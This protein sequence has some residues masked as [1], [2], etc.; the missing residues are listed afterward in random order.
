MIN[1]SDSIS[2]L[3]TSQHDAKETAL[4][5]VT[6]SAG[7]RELI[8][9]ATR[10]AKSSASILLTGDSGTGKEL[11]AQLIHARSRRQDE[12]FVSVNCASL[13]MNLIESELFG[14][15]KGAF[16]DA[17][18]NRVGRFELAQGGTL[19]LDEITEIPLVTQAKLLRV[20]EAKEFQK[21]GC[22]DTIKTDVRVVA[23]SNRDLLQQVDRGKFRLDLYHRLN[24][25]QLKVPSLKERTNDIPLLASHFVNLFAFENE[26][27]VKGF[28]NA[29]MKKLSRHE[30]P[31]NVRELRNTVHRACIMTDRPL[32][33]ANVLG[34]FGDEAIQSSS[35]LPEMWLQTKL[36]DIEKQI[37]IA[38]MKRFD[39]NRIVAEKLGISTRTLTNKLKQYR[40]EDTVPNAGQARAA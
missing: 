19:L 38:A 25:I 17:M 14:H 36:A 9:T 26:N 1:L 34:D 8:N 15:R 28:T 16:T 10:V 29:A 39:S 35:T 22:N 3:S 7:M 24:V 27:P 37:I 6:Q 31:G 33:D 20:L 30:W 2:Q 21:V 32:I 5:I 18:E 11:F 23:T 40:E 4:Q 12:A 13:P